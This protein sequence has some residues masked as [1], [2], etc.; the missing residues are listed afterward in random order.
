M[1]LS[2]NKD[3]TWIYLVVTHRRLLPNKNVNSVV[4]SHPCRRSTLPLLYSENELA[5][6]HA[7]IP[8]DTKGFTY[9]KN[10]LWIPGLVSPGPQ[11][12]AWI[13]RLLHRG[14][15]RFGNQHRQGYL[16]G[17]TLGRSIAKS[18]GLFGS[19]PKVDHGRNIPT[20]YVGLHP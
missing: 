18:P 19:T 12:G 16:M 6:V 17:R 20:Y 13:V 14:L 2:E 5:S 11:I 15:G 7:H 4:A 1:S 8:L 3:Y 10:P 9:S